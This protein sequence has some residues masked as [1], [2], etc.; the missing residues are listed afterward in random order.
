MTNKSLFE[1]REHHTH[2]TIHRL[3]T[4]YSDLSWYQS[5]WHLPN[6]T[7]RRT[8]WYFSESL[9]ESRPTI[10]KAWLCRIHQRAEWRDSTDT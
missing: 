6:S 7:N 9:D 3:R 10:D 1:R 4:T 8:L 2:H 5:Q